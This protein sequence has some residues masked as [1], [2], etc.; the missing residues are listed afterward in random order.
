MGLLL[1]E[2]GEVGGSLVLYSWEV[3]ADVPTRLARA[4]CHLA[5]KK[6]MPSAPSSSLPPRNPSGSD[7]PGPVAPPGFHGARAR[8]R[9]HGTVIRN[10]YRANENVRTGLLFFIREKCAVVDPPGDK[11]AKAVARYL[12]CRSTHCKLTRVSIPKENRQI[13]IFFLYRRKLYA[14]CD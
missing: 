7:T 3:A 13:E 11:A 4:R 9:C 5:A 1:R 10:C 12:N 8:H 2:R 14:A 6:T